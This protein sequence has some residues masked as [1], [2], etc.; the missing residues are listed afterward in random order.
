MDAAESAKV[1]LMSL[2]SILNTRRQCY[3]YFVSVLRGEKR[4]FDRIT[5]INVGGISANEM[6]GRIDVMRVSSFNDSFD[7]IKIVVSSQDFIS[8]TEKSQPIS[9][10][11]LSLAELG[12][13]DSRVYY[14]LDYIYGR[15]RQLGLDLC[16]QDLGLFLANDERINPADRDD[17]FV[18]SMP[19]EATDKSD[20]ILNLTDDGE[21]AVFAAKITE[22]TH[23]ESDDVFYF[24]LPA[25]FKR[26]TK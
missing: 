13:S 20:F 2:R 6:I 24:R 18:A 26:K 11:R 19:I 23:W 16:P 7:D 10:I 9:V 17:T 14:D 22:T 1:L 21:V 8:H 5:E 4:L 3:R 15:A 12:L 25:G